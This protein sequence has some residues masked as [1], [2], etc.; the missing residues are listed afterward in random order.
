MPT[1]QIDFGVL[2]AIVAAVAALIGL[3]F[4]ANQT[5]LTRRATQLQA[6]QTLWGNFDDE[7][8]RDYRRQIHAAIPP[9]ESKRPKPSELDPAV[10]NAIEVTATAMDRVGSLMA[11]HLVAD[12]FIFE[13]YS[14]V[15]IPLWE[16]VKPY[17]DERRGEK[18]SGWRFFGPLPG[19]PPRGGSA[20]D[21]YS[22][23][24]I[25]REKHHPHERYT[26]FTP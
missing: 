15:I 22:R 11:H 21:L 16:K 13:R 20:R 8:M 18:G 2:A 6:I 12:D 26:T 3:V 5:L 23:A 24:R 25:Y 19:P 9:D 14:E 10:R 4:A 7:K 1:I 17:I